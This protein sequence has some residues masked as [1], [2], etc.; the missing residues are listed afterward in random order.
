[1][2]PTDI[3]CALLASSLLGF[4]SAT[5]PNLNLF[6]YGNSGSLL[7][8]SFGISGANATFDY[9]VVGGGNAGLTIA[10]RLAENQTVSVAVIEAGGFYETDNG[11]YSTVPGYSSHYTG[12]DP[13]DY[14]P[15]IDWGFSTQPQPGSG[16]RVLH[17]ARGKT[18]GGS[19]ARNYMLYQRPTIDSM[20]RWADE[21]DDQSYTFERLL[22]Y[23]KK[24]VHYTPPN[25]ALYGNSTNSQ[26]PDAF[27]PTG[28]PLE[29]S[30]SNAVHAFGTWC[31][32]AFLALGMKQI[33][34]FNSGG[35]L[36]SAFV[37]YTIDPRNAHR[38]SSESSFLQTVLSKGVGPTVYKNTMAQKI[39][40]DRDD[41]HATGVQVSTG[42]T[43]GTRSVNFTLHARTEVIISAGAFQSPQLL[44]VSGIGPCDHLRSFNIPCIKNLPGVGQN[45]QDHPTFPISHRVNVLTTSA[46]ASNATIAALNVKQYTENATGPLS[47]FG[48]GYYSWEKL[49]D[50]FRSNLTRESRLAL[51]SFPPDWPELEWLPV[52]AF[53][54][55][56]LNKVTADPKDG[57]QYATLSGA[58]IAPLSRGSVR[59]AGPSMN[60][61]PLIDPQWFTDPTDVDLAIQ[62]F[63][64][65]RQI[66]AELA[67]LGVAEHEEYFPGFNVSTDAQILE[68]IHQSMI[69]VYHASATCKMGRKNDTMAVVD[70]HANVYGV[71]GLKVVDASSFPFLPPGHPQSIVYAFAEKI[72]DEILGFVG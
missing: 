42:G 43:F 54:G 63:K 48:P 12:S 32:K 65:Q 67:K 62:G 41:K 66:W 13:T 7:G 15:L 37:T 28:G 17:Y 31:Q 40:F 16:G 26:T 60:T 69:T 36:G 30:F 61:P 64:R 51:S 27:S 55:Y 68:F 24:S 45:M 70:S 11:N 53:N 58:L 56:N 19:S 35:L 1:M 20:Q 44:M 2:H 57:H 38:S 29:V 9:V 50:P 21:V 34:G 71:R 3:V 72:A 6:A 33:D 5:P 46:S 47:I 49:P 10:S 25:Q 14:Q 8:T 23:F 52:S 39:L 18:L 22:P 4:A 59:L